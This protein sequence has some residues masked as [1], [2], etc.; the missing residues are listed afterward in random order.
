MNRNSSTTSIKFCFQS[1]NCFAPPSKG[2]FSWI[3]MDSCVSRGSF[4]T[5]SPS[6]STAILPFSVVACKTKAGPHQP[7]SAS[8]FVLK[9][10]QRKLNLLRATLLLEFRKIYSSVSDSSLFNWTVSR[11]FLLRNIIDSLTL[12]PLSEITL[13]R[14]IPL[15]LRK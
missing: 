11:P 9:S 7:L 12:H 4:R 5:S 14:L 10:V 2:I 15:Q 8:S 13:I 1:D 6:P 3:P